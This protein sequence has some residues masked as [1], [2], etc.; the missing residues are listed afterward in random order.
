MMITSSAIEYINFSE[1]DQVVI[2][3]NGGRDY[4][5]KCN[6]L[7]GFQNDLYDV[8]EEGESVGQFVNRAIKAKLLQTV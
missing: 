8:I 3:F 4:T 2:T 5:Y 1:N 6:D 7:V